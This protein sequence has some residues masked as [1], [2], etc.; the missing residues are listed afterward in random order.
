MLRVWPGEWG[1]CGQEASPNL[2]IPRGCSSADPGEGTPDLAWEAGGCGAWTL[3]LLRRGGPCPPSQLHTHSWPAALPVSAH[4]HSLSLEV[5][6]ICSQDRSFLPAGPP[7]GGVSLFQPQTKS[8]RL[9][10]PPSGS[11][12]PGPQASAPGASEVGDPCPSTSQLPG[13]EALKQDTVSKEQSQE[14]PREGGSLAKQPPTLSRV[15]I[16]HGWTSVLLPR[17][18]SRAVGT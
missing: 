15:S 17:R 3:C 5:R 11:V 9:H 7:A 12:T 10:Q 14:A 4:T 2:Q 16:L 18:W 6:T 1:H 8:Q 13:G